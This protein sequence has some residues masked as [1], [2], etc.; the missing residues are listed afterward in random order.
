MQSRGRGQRGL[1]R[2]GRASG[3]PA[4]CHHP[5]PAQPHQ[6]EAPGVSRLCQWVSGSRALWEGSCGTGARCW[7]HL[8]Q[9][10]IGSISLT[11]LS[12]ECGGFSMLSKSADPYQPDLPQPCP[13]P[14]PY[15]SVLGIPLP[16]CAITA[17]WESKW[18]VLKHCPA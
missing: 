16:P 5:C 2:M 6:L 3:A 12:R 9:L 13:H 10:R 4:Q 17:V 8:Q 1:K 7:H 15:T 18:C 11:C 14:P